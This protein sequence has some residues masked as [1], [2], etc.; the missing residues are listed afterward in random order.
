[1][2]KESLT[3]CSEV[4]VPVEVNDYP[5]F[6]FYALSVSILYLNNGV[7]VLD[8]ETGSCY[9]AQAGL[10]LTIPIVPQPPEC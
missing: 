5:I 7:L 2:F 6:L 8:F 10:E 4:Q 9:T 1:M 3:V